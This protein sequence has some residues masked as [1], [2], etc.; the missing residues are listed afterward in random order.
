MSS[1]CEPN[2]VWNK[3]WEHGRKEMN[4]GRWNWSLNSTGLVVF[5][6]GFTFLDIVKQGF[7][8]V[9]LLRS[10]ITALLGVPRIISAENGV[11]S[12][13]VSQ[14][15][16]NQ[17]RTQNRHW[18]VDHLFQLWQRIDSFQN[19]QKSNGWFPWVPEPSKEILQDKPSL[20]QTPTAGR[21][22]MI[23]KMPS[24]LDHFATGTHIDPEKSTVY[25]KI[26]YRWSSR[27]KIFPW[28]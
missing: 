5:V 25:K 17:K 24:F 26:I 10:K 7:F 9:P 3:N 15:C 14:I 20:F 22:S 6:L 1:R 8:G 19:T 28:E 2:F 13:F 21:T 16:G 18:V 12:G 4:G 27:Y 11:S 23:W